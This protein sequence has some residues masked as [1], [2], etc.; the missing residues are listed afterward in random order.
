M[1]LISIF[2]A[3]K[4]N[5]KS[6]KIKHSSVLTREFIKAD[7]LDSQRLAKLFNFLIRASRTNPINGKINLGKRLLGQCRSKGNSNKNEGE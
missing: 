4:P 5:F 1:R 2:R 6:L 7:Y 3:K